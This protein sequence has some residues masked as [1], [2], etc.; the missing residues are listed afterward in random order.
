VVGL[1]GNFTEA[2]KIARADLPEDEAAANVRYLRQ[3]LSQ[4]NEWKK[5]GRRP[6]AP[7]RGAGS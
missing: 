6:N 2:E 4:Q 3:M 7:A 1:Q 5:M